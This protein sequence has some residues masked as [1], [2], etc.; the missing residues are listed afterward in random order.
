M[1]LAMMG[2]LGGGD[3]WMSSDKSYSSPLEDSAICL[4]DN[5]SLTSL[6]GTSSINND[7]INY[8]SQQLCDSNNNNDSNQINN[9][10]I[11]HNNKSKLDPNSKPFSPRCGNLPKDDYGLRGL[12]MLIEESR[13]SLLSPWSSIITPADLGYSN[14]SL[15]RSRRLESPYRFKTPFSNNVLGVLNDYYYVPKEYLHSS[16]LYDQLPLPG[17]HYWPTDLLFF[18]FYTAVGE[19]LQ[20]I[21]GYNLFD[22]GW[23]FN[24]L[25]RT[26]IARIPQVPLEERSYEFE[27]GTYQYFD[28]SS[29][30]K[31]TAKLTLYY[32]EFSDRIG[33]PEDYK[34]IYS[35]GAYI[36]SQQAAIAAA[37]K[38]KEAAAIAYFKS[39]KSAL[40]NGVRY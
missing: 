37:H 32:K 3:T 14:Y 19:V 25:T 6:S 20:L 39:M 38:R 12:E 29:G 11:I 24:K 27:R 26:W 5:Q 1:S 2:S 16:I 13:K 7:T 31:K 8:L 22:R 17:S 21:A 30:S 40:V 28:V 36:G 34:G 15:S 18:L 4:G 9:N 35:S 33:L 10:L 23:R